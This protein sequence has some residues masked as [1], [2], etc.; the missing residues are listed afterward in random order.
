LKFVEGHF[1]EYQS[2]FDILLV[3]QKHYIEKAQKL[4]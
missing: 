4:E 2:D 1:E 3:V